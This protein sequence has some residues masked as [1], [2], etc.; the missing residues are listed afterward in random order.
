MPLAIT[1]PNNLP[2]IIDKAAQNPAAVLIFCVVVFAT[3]V[4]IFFA[5]APLVVRI[6]IL[7]FVV[8]LLAIVVILV[9]PTGG[10]GAAAF[11]T[12]KATNAATSAI[13]QPMA[14]GMNNA[15]VK[16]LK[17][18]VSD[19]TKA[20]AP[21]SKQR[22]I[23]VARPGAT[24]KQLDSDTQ[25]GFYDT[26]LSELERKLT[27]AHVAPDGVKFM[28]GIGA[29]EPH[30]AWI[31]VLVRE[32]DDLPVVYSVKQEPNPGLVGTVEARITQLLNALN[33]REILPIGWTYHSASYIY[34]TAEL[35][36]ETKSVSR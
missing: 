17:T 31:W 3:I 13:E 11:Y 33:Q 2:E 7:A 20:I 8:I 6:G 30:R 24:W 32:G 36:S 26:Q 15:A 14:G 9:R 25:P 1:L 28:F 4:V 21:L 10:F 22:P 18:N 34:A 35:Q 16:Q 12:Y 29:D 19:L 23:I 5:R 27:E